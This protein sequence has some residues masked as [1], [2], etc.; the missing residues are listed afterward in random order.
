MLDVKKLL[1]KIL[2]HIQP[3][4]TIVSGTNSTT[5]SVPKSSKT[6]TTS[7]SLSAGKWLV[8]FQAA[9]NI[10][11]GTQYQATITTSYD[12]S[13]E[14]I[15]AGVGGISRLNMVAILNL[16]SQTTVYGTM[17]QNSNSDITVNANM[18]NAIRII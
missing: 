14:Q 12:V 1:T 10:P 15:M 5:I 6:N 18:I 9:L 3:I 7:V 11:A 16:G 2:Q 4:G 8:V 17:Y 13:A